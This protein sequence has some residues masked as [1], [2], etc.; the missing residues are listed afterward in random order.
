MHRWDTILVLPHGKRH[1][2]RPVCVWICRGCGML[3]NSSTRKSVPICWHRWED[4]RATAAW[5]A[6]MRVVNQHRQDRE[7]R[8]DALVLEQHDQERQRTA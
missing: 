8:R 2:Q 6:Y 3:W 5:E 1:R 7:R 4:P